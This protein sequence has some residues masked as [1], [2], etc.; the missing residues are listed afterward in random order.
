MVLQDGAYFFFTIC[1]C[2]IWEMLQQICIHCFSSYEQGVNFSLVWSTVWISGV[3][4]CCRYVRSMDGVYFRTPVV[5]IT[6]MPIDKWRFVVCECFGCFLWLKFFLYRIFIIYIHFLL[7]NN[8]I[9]VT[10]YIFLGS[11]QFSVVHTSLLH[12]HKDLKQRNKIC[13]IY[14]QLMDRM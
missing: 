2:Q 8:I 13:L 3:F 6:S 7:Y 9:N 1:Y 5:H 14:S 10:I 11:V 4:I 12:W